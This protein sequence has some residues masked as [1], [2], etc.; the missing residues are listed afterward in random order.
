[1]YGK[2]KYYMINSALDMRLLYIFVCFFNIH[3]HDISIGVYLN[4]PPLFSSQTL[5]SLC[6]HA[7]V[8]VCFDI[9]LCNKMKIKMKPHPKKKHTHTKQNDRPKKVEMKTTKP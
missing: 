7:C 4:F 8:C 1:M 5:V 2:R 6:I 9:I 3:E